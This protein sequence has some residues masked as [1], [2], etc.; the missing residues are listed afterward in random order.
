MK[1]SEIRK[2][3]REVIKD[4]YNHLRTKEDYRKAFELINDVIL[5]K[6]VGLRKFIM[7]EVRKILVNKFSSLFIKKK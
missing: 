1:K 5:P 4:N 7:E 2:L 6:Q 3:A